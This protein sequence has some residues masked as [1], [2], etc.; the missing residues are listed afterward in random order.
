[1]NINEQS[2]RGKVI[3]QPHYLCIT[4]DI[5]PFKTEI[6]ID[7]VVDDCMITIYAN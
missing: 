2:I 7:G 5:V 4:W 3:E 6:H 1:M